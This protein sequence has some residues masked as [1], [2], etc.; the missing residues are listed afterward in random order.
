MCTI[1]MNEKRWIKS[2]LVGQGSRPHHEQDTPSHSVRPASSRTN[3]AGAP[4]RPASDSA[5]YQVTLSGGPDR[6]K[7]SANAG[8]AYPPS[9][10]SAAPPRLHPATSA[11]AFAYWPA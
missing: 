5:S 2:R 4:K 6:A 10:L 11:L 1:A 9:A 8:R 7:Q 3:L